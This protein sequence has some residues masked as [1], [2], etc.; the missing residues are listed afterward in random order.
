[1]IPTLPPN[2]SK[3]LRA[4]WTRLRKAQE[5]SIRAADARAALP[6][7]SSRAKVTSANARWGSAAE[8]RDRAFDAYQTALAAENLAARVRGAT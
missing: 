8:D 7:G 1:M 4:L 6:P 3:E 5:A 2:P